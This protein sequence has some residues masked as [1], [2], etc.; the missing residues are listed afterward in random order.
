MRWDI[1]TEI[2][3]NGIIQDQHHCAINLGRDIFG[4]EEESD[5]G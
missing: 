1:L 3:N 2:L 4:F 5:V